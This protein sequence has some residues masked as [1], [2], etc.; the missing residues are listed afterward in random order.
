MLG[1]DEEGEIRRARLGSNNGRR[2]QNSEN[3]PMNEEE[4]K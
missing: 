3:K 2:G 4:N 1:D